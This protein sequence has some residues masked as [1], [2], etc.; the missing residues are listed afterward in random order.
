MKIPESICV[1]R[2]SSLGDIV[3]TTVLLR[4]L[5]RQ[6]PQAYIVM[7]VAEQYYEAVRFNIHCSAIV[8]VHTKNGLKGLLEARRKILAFTQGKKFDVVI[9]LHKIYERHS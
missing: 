1:F 3:L 9:D 5:R 8:T 4:R 2:L 7:V 6:Y